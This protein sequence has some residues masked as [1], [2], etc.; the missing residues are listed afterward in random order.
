MVVVVVAAGLEAVF[1][2]EERFCPSSISQIKFL[3]PPQFPFLNNPLLDVTWMQLLVLRSVKYKH[4]VSKIRLNNDR[5][6]ICNAYL[7]LEIPMP[8]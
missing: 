7:L 5:F 8:S 4:Q 6:V 3:S 1:V 2:V